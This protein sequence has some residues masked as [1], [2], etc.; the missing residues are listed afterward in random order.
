[1]NATEKPTEDQLDDLDEGMMQQT[2]LL[3]GPEA[4][5]LRGK[6]T[7]VMTKEEYHQA[8]CDDRSTAVTEHGA[9]LDKQ[10]AHHVE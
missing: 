2:V 6:V 3:R 5:T 8:L 9:Y 4:E 7:D 1:M 10:M